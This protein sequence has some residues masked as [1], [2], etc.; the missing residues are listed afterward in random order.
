MCVAFKARLNRFKQM[1][2]EN[3]SCDNGGDP[4]V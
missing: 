2:F 3:G 4:S 1:F